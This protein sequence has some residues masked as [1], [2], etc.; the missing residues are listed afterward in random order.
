MVAIKR[1]LQVG[2]AVGIRGWLVPQSNWERDGERLCHTQTWARIIATRTSL[3]KKR[4]EGGLTGF[5]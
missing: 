1:E 4:M 2:V 5:F 3:K